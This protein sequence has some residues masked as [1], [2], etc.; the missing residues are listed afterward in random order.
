MPRP[1]KSAIRKPAANKAKARGESSGAL[2]LSIVHA[3]K[4]VQARASK[5]RVA[6][7]LAENGRSGPGKALKALLALP[8]PA[9]AAKRKGWVDGLHGIHM[10][11]LDK[12]WEPTPDGINFAAIVC[13]V[14]KHLAD[15]AIVT[16]DAGNF[17][18]YVHRYIGF[19]QTQE[20]H[21]SI[22]GAMGFSRDR[23]SV[24]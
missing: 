9:D 16:T 23:K 7:W 5:A 4:L 14:D 13:E 1:V 11:L 12:K 2:A 20:F 17:G 6:E 3:P 18:S 10:G 8:A 19:K 22:V 24:V 15:D 21:S